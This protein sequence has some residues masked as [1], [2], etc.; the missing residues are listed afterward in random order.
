MQKEDGLNIFRILCC[1]GVLVY[2]VFDDILSTTFTIN[3]FIYFA[4]SFCVPG[5]FLLSGYLI[6]KKE[7]ISFKYIIT[8]ILKLL[9][10]YSFCIIIFCI[11]KFILNGELLNPISEIIKGLFASAIL[12]VGWFI[13][14]LSILILSSYFLH[15]LCAYNKFLY[16]LLLFFII[17]LNFVIKIDITVV[18][19]LWILLYLM[20]Y[21]I[22]ILLSKIVIKR[23]VYKI[24]LVIINVFTFGYYIITV[25][26]ANIFLNPNN[27]YNKWY[28]F[29]WIVSMFFLLKNVNF[30]NN[31]IKKFFDN[32]SKNT[33][34]VYLF[35]LPILEVITYYITIDSPLKAGICVLVLFI[36]TQLISEI[37]KKIPF[38]NQLI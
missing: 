16:I 12:P 5:F 11:F 8:K 36:L 3:N 6:G 7:S 14:T 34:A 1:L 13:F 35:H 32:L 24:L 21:M 9:F 25:K 23:K 19:S 31:S 33:L 38:L 26:N 2:H 27:Y 18:Q 15:K 20:Y 4:F 22:G 29:I 28:Y 30:N 37:L 10:F 17:V